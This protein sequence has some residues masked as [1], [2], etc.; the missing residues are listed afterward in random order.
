VA[1]QN[2]VLQ[3][4]L[5]EVIDDRL[6]RLIEPRRLGVA[7]PVSPDCRR[8]DLVA[9]SAD[10]SCDGLELGAGVPGAVNQDVG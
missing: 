7:G 3:I 8:E 1:E 9:G 6:D 2:H 5:C 10:D 4:V